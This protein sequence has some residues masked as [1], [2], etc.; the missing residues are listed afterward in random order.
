M[1]LPPAT[2]MTTKKTHKSKSPPHTPLQ[3]AQFSTNTCMVRLHSDDEEEAGD[4][5]E[6]DEEEEEDDDDAQTGNKRKADDDDDANDDDSKAP[7]T[8]E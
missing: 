3:L 5:D 1:K 7:K 4:D 2:T 8:D 6:E